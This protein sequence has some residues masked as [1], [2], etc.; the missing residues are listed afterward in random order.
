[1]SFKN[2]SNNLLIRSLENINNRLRTGGEDELSK[3]Q[4]VAQSNRIIAELE[5]RGIEEPGFL[6]KRNVVKPNKNDVVNLDD[7]DKVDTSGGDGDDIDIMLTGSGSGQNRLLGIINNQVKNNG[8]NN[9]REDEA[10]PQVGDPSHEPMLY[11]SKKYVRKSRGVN[12]N[13]KL[14]IL[15]IL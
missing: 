4:S 2:I 5:K 14:N 11:E 1:M 12:R 13:T 8:I 10:R 3:E 7:D 9:F 15:S 6:F